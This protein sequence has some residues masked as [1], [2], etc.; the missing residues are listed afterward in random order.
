[1]EVPLQLRFQIPLHD[2]LCHTVRD[3][4]NAQRPDTTPCLGYFNQQHRW[5]HVTARTHPVPEFVEVVAKIGFKRFQTL[6]VVTRS[7]LA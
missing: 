2:H 3:G 7:A 4:R 1:M 5:W 6:A